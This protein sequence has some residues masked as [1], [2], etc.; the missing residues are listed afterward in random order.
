MLGR[1]VLLFTD[2]RAAARTLAGHLRGAG[3][4]VV[5]A[6]SSV[7]AHDLIAARAVD[8]VFVDGEAAGALD[9][10]DTARGLVPT[11]VIS[12][13]GEPTMMLE[14]VCMRGV[15]HVLVR[16]GDADGSLVDLAREVVVT[17]E[18]ILRADLFGLD[19]YLPSFGVELS[20]AEVRCAL[21]RDGV[22]EAIGDHAEWLGAGREARRAVA[23][24]VDELVTNAV[25][26]APRDGA[27]NA[28]YHATDRRTKVELD[29]WEYVSVAWGSDGD[30]IAISVT[31]SFG[32]LEP[33][34]VRRGL[35]RCLTSADPI[36]QKAGGAGLGLFTA[37]AYCSQLV[38][39]VDRGVR[40]EMIAIIDLRRRTAGVRRAGRSLHLFFEDSRAAAAMPCDAAPTSIEVSDSMLVDVREHLAPSKRRVDIVPLMRPRRPLPGMAPRAR[41]SSPPPTQEP[42]GADTAC[43]LLRGAT[44]PET[45]VQIGLRFLANH[46]DAAVAYAVDG[47]HV[48]AT[49][50]SGQVRDWPKLRALRLTR[51]ET[52]SIAAMS[53]RDAATPFTPAC[54]LDFRIAMV[55]TGNSEAAGLV[56][57]LKVDGELR[58]I[59]YGAGP[60]DDTPLLPDVVE[61][62]RCELAGH[63]QRLDPEQTDI[64]ITPGR[65][66]LRVAMP[67]PAP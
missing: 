51:D 19:K 14:L 4:E 9:L 44:T 60:H 37:L 35:E 2:D 41:G 47:H 55:A 16:S 66:Q 43:G 40:T 56:M 46:Y 26:D 31:D 1:T 39:N 34:H 57:P 49:F 63:L 7:A 29:P 10:V 25:Y 24:V 58:W 18:K 42:V 32:A 28:R 22:V 48:E 30:S 61:K 5:I 12:A 21:D 65:G 64:D 33:A 53:A 45:A 38:V 67:L 36:E 6:E 13:G 8:L 27:G 54:P 15:E 3:N 52:A 20:T 23:A 62:V 50:A 17:A 11:V 59:L